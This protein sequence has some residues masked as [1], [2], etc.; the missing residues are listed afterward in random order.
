MSYIDAP[1]TKQPKRSPRELWADGKPALG[2]MLMIPSA[3]SAEI[4]VAAG[5]EG[6]CFGTQHGLMGSE[7][8]L[9]MVQALDQRVTTIIRVAW[10]EPELIM[11]ALDTG[12]D[13]VIVPMVNNRAD[14]EAA[15]QA[16]RFP[17]RGIRSWGQIRAALGHP[18]FSPETENERVFCA[19]MIETAEAMGN[20]EEI[21]SVEGVHAVFVGPSDLSISAMGG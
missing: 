4:V 1:D 12:A 10:N 21:M 14:A 2:C 11:K 20:L 6:V 19:V 16:F 13:G 8:T 5:Y 18:D 3:L 9:S 7:T 15:A 17:P